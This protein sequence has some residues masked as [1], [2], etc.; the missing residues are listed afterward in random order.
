MQKFKLEYCD[1]F[2]DFMG[3]FLEV[4]LC[5]VEFNGWLRNVYII[6]LFSFFSVNF[7]EFVEFFS[8]FKIQ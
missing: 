8:D 3:D 1:M 5:C 7:I 4:F 2:E 6:F